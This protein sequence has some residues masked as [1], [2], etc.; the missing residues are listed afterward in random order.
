LAAR[1]KQVS[2]HRFTTEVRRFFKAGKSDRTVQLY[3]TSGV[4]RSIG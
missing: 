3:F 4:R 1:G 2:R